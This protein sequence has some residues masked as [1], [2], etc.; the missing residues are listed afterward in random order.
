MSDVSSNKTGSEFPERGPAVAW[1]PAASIA[2]TIL[3]L[4]G[5][6]FLAGFV[7]A[8]AAGVSLTSTIGQFCF[9]LISD[10][11]ILLAIWAFLR[12]RKAK[13][14]D[15]G[16]ARKPAWKDLGYALLAWLVYFGVF[17]MLA[18]LAD[19]FTQ[20]N[21]DQKQELG[22]EQLFGT[23]EK[24]IAL[25][26]LVVLPPIVEEIVFRGFM[27][28]GMRRKFRFAAAALITSV[29]FASLHLLASSE[30]LLW[31]AGLDTLIL[32]L[33]LC[34]LREKTGA[35]WAPMLLHGIKNAIAFSILLTGVAVL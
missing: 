31:I 19:A 6:Q 10:V 14:S 15:I 32:S 26:S 9:V 4:F 7:I 34:Y 21:V 18:V 12:G 16:F 5:G 8:S 33:V 23:T 3:S 29:A 1:G 13:F 27:F 20:I 17:V 22:F 28:T 35:L 30:G 25:I 24:L 2:V 11:L